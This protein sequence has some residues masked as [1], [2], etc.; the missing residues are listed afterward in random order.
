[1]QLIEIPVS[2]KNYLFQQ[3]SCKEQSIRFQYTSQAI[4]NIELILTTDMTSWI[5]LQDD[6]LF[7]FKEDIC[8]PIFGGQF[9]AFKDYIITIGL[10]A[11]EI[12]MLSIMWEK[13][14][15]EQFIQ[16]KKVLNALSDPQNY[17]LYSVMQQFTPKTQ[18]GMTTTYFNEA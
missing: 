7:G 3:F 12:T 13:E 16:K 6:R 2:S 1:M 4:Q 14:P 15:L 11:Q 8:G 10:K 9:N 5:K 17:R 18:W